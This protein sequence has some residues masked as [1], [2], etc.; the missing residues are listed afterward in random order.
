ML[1][2]KLEHTNEAYAIAKIVGL[3]SCEFY[4][5]QFGTS[6]FTLMPTN[7]YGPN[8]NFETKTSHFIPALIK[9]FYLANKK[10]LRN[11]EVWG[12]GRPKREIMHVDDLASAVFFIINKVERKHKKVLKVLKRN[13]YINVGSNKEYS[14]K[15][16]A[17]MIAKLFPKKVNLKFNKK[18]PDGTSRKLLNSSII[19]DMGWKTNI[20]IKKGLKET[21][22]WYK[23]KYK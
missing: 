23:K 6:Y 19:N 14:I 18:Y 8:D 1:T 3:K 9:K 11:V 20:P 12:T 15:Q 5:R 7:L 16:Y 22:E 17:N 10:N 4:N 21:L 13:S 2:G